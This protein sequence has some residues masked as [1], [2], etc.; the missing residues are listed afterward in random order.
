MTAIVAVPAG[1]F[2][3][4]VGSFLN[5]VIHRVPQSASIVRPASACPACGTPIQLRDNIPILSWIL[6]RGRCRACATPIS[7]RYPLVE[8]VTGALWILAVIRA[9][10]L[11]QA[12]FIAVS[13][14]ALIALS[15]IDLA[16]RR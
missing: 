7:A 4:A 16:H 1:L 13:G 15:F 5:V 10:T 9:A 11:E 12:A 2:G 14:S 3:A 6:L 8:A